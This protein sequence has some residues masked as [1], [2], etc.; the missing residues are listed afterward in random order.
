[1]ASRSKQ[2]AGQR[3]AGRYV[4]R[5]FVASGSPSS[6]RAEKAVEEIGEVFLKGN[7]EIEIVD[8]RTDH[9]KALEANVLVT[10]TLIVVEPQPAVR[11][12]GSLDDRDKVLSAL[13]IVTE[14]Q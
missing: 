3:P 10:P 5:L 9:E 11:I 4:L 1:M 6:A 14:G 8:V 7:Y 2:E 12:V 13:R